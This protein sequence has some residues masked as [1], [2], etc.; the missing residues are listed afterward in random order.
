[1]PW[2]AN[3]DEFFNKHLAVYPMTNP[4]TPAPA[5]DNAQPLYRG[6]RRPIHQ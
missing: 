5:L 4:K 3:S 1:M 2:P 6:V